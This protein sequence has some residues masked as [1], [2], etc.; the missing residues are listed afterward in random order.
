MT[1][2]IL[3]FLVF[4]CVPLTSAQAFK[5]EGHVWLASQI[6]DEIFSNDGNTSND[7]FVSIDGRSYPLSPNIRNALQQNRGAFLMGVMGADIYPDMLAGQ[8]TTHPGVP[9]V[10][11]SNV[12]WQTDDWLEYVL[13]EALYSDRSSPAAIAFAA[14]YVLHASMDMWA[15]TWV[16]GYVGDTFSIIKNAETAERHIAIEAY[17]KTF[18]KTLISDDTNP[19]DTTDA[20]SS[21]FAPAQFVSETLILNPTVATQYRQEVST[22]Y[23]AALWDY[24]AFVRDDLKPST[25]GVINA[26]AA[27]FDRIEPIIAQIKTHKATVDGHRLALE[28]HLTRLK[29]GAQQTIDWGVSLAE[30]SGLLGAVESVVGDV[31][32]DAPATLAKQALELA[33]A[34]YVLEVQKLNYGIDEL[35]NP[36]QLRTQFVNAAN[37]LSVNVVDNWV[38]NI[39]NSMTQYIRAWELTAKELM[40]PHGDRFTPGNKPLQPMI[41]WAKCWS[42]VLSTPLPLIAADGA[43]VCTRTLEGYSDWH[44]QITLVKNNIGNRI[45]FVPA[46]KEAVSAFDEQAAVFTGVQSK[47]VAN[48]LADVLPPGSPVDF[49]ALANTMVTMW[50]KH[51]SASGLDQA[52]S[53]STSEVDLVE[54]P[55]STSVHKDLGVCSGQTV[56]ASYQAPPISNFA[57]MQNAVTMSKLALLNSQQLNRV[58]SH[59]ETANTKSSSRLSATFSAPTSVQTN[60]SLLP[61]YQSKRPM[62]TVLF[63]AL[64][65]IDGN[66]QWL[67]QAPALPRDPAQADEQCR[68]FGYP[69]SGAQYAPCNTASEDPFNDYPFQLQQN[70]GFLIAQGPRKASVF[71]KLFDPVHTNLCD[72]LA[73]YGLGA[74]ICGDETTSVVTAPTTNTHRQGA[75]VQRKMAP[76]KKMTTSRTASKQL[77]QRVSQTKRTPVRTRSAGLG[78]DGVFNAFSAQA[79]QHNWQN[80]YLLSLL[81]YVTYPGVVSGARMDRSALQAQIER[82]GLT[83]VDW[84]DITTR[85]VNSGSTQFLVAKNSNAL[86]IAFRG[87]T[88]TPADLGQDWLDNNLDFLPRPKPDWGRGVVM[89]DGFLDAAKIVFDRVANIVRA[90]AGKRKVWITGHSL[91]G[92]VA[93]LNAFE[94]ERRRLSVGGVYTFGAPPVGNKAWH[95]VYQKAV[96][97][98]HRWS[99]QNDP[100]TSMMVQLPGPFEHVGRRHNLL[101]NGQVDLNHAQEFVYPLSA[102]PTQI[103]TDLASTHMSYWCRLREQAI[104]SGGMVN[105]PWPPNSTCYACA[106]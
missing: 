31:Q 2:R 68:R 17:L 27:E 13:D 37:A 67:A 61:Q 87:S 80:T 49:V 101:A 100:V 6:Y 48:A 94:L 16:N 95:D 7:G 10:I 90:H 23:L 79:T 86:F 85:G 53:K 89:H 60:P 102:I 97:N 55:I 54:K 52:Y 20:Y 5:I 64:R 66:H 84:A 4:C 35:L 42:P 25:Q 8:M 51:P 36:D 92:A 105:P 98:T 74:Q 1:L 78:S 71:D 59:L 32:L 26:L 82:W 34:A 72:H 45:P 21:L 88:I 77:G 28:G 11:G 47:Q 39:E 104:S 44:D 81:S 43:Y 46:L 96:P 75:V 29:D 63:G 18:H 58:M 30:S 70:T 3:Y 93:V 103:V 91:G 14:G 57:P 40:R 41:N 15:H 24:Y 73:H 56:A 76:S 62:G 83:F 65:S 33:H 50:D 99:V 9:T 38:V 22:M 106:Y 69:S 12:A 19:H